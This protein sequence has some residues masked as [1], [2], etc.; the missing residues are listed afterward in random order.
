M[1]P[2]PQRFTEVLHLS[3]YVSTV[4][5][6]RHDAA[7]ADEDAN[8][9]ERGKDD[10]VFCLRTAAGRFRSRYYLVLEDDVLVRDGALES[11]NFV[12]NYFGLFAADDWLFLKLYYPDKWSGYGR[13]VD[14]L[15]ELAGYSVL[16][17]SLVAAAASRRLLN[18][19]SMPRS[20]WVVSGSVFAAL[21]C[22]G[23]GRQ[24]VESWRGHFASTHRLVAAPG[25]CTQATLYPARVVPDVVTHL[26]RVR[27]DY[28]F[29]VDV[30]LDGLAQLRGLR[31]HLLQPNVVKHI[32]LVSS[33]RRNSK[34]AIHF[35]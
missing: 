31:R 19:R 33:L 8:I 25:C 2:Q 17:G 13:S 29:S 30:A 7:A 6:Y 10:Y 27:S 32:G 14:T 15:A 21:V 22:V 11:V 4:F 9:F 28:D 16:G 35:L 12:M 20:F 23:V 18:C 3:S 1:D 5:R 26:R 34:S 24:Y